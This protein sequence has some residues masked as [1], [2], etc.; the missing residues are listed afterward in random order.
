MKNNR[1][2]SRNLPE[3]MSDG[4]SNDQD[5]R[6]KMWLNF[7]PLP[8]VRK[9]DIIVSNWDKRFLKYDIY[10]R[11]FKPT[12]VTTK[13]RLKGANRFMEHQIR[14]MRKCDTVTYWRIAMSLVG[15]SNIFLLMAINHVFPA[16]Y[17]DMKLSSVI[18]LTRETRRIAKDPDARLNFR[19]IYIPKG[20][21]GIRPL[22][23]PTPAWRVYLHMITQVI[24]FY[25]ETRNLAHESQ[26]GFRPGRGT[27]TAWKVIL[28]KVIDS[29]D[30][31]EFDLK[32]F[33]DTINLDYVGMKMVG[34]GIPVELARRM[35]LINTSA[36]ITK[37]PY[38][39]SEFEHKMKELLYKRSAEEIITAP[40]PLSWRYRVKGVPQGAPTS[41]VLSTLA[42][43]GSIL[44]RGVNTVMYADDGLYYGDIDVPL[45]TPNSGMVTANIYF[46]L[47]KTGWVKRNGEWLKPL[48][49]LGLEYDGDTLKAATRKGSKLVFDKQKLV[50][51]IT[52]EEYF[53]ESDGRDVINPDSNSFERMVKDKI[54]N[55]IQSRLYQG[56]WNVGE[57]NG[58]FKHLKASKG[59]MLHRSTKRNRD[60]YNSSSFCN[61]WML[62][63]M[64]KIN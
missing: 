25:L 52:R 50:D 18:L 35:Y 41:P 47:G 60:L 12:L 19:R 59:S 31:F 16:W 36:C 33:F 53:V 51:E 4:G 6:R 46:N 3:A 8:N 30:I 22:G 14:R 61:G 64:R 13:Y 5:K 32:G 42:L 58:L 38:L 26:H 10:K 44:D 57:I 2:S 34:K 1:E 11:E 15:R 39:L 21:K 37:P 29:R 45:I 17:K 48:K 9:F 23:V 62:N 43:E 55:F 63:I 28:D 54:W 40:R 27:G 7:K 49:F 24:T 56:D 20:D